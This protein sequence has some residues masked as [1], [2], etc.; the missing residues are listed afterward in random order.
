[1]LTENQFKNIKLQG[2]LVFGL[3]FVL[4][5]LSYFTGDNYDECVKNAKITTGKLTRYQNFRGKHYYLYFYKVGNRY[6]KSEGSF[7]ENKFPHLYENEIERLS[8]YVLYR[9]EGNY[10][11]MIIFD[12]LPKQ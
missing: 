4:S 5:L 8:I 3:L 2:F 10:R 1:M 7:Y 9:A 12:S 6:L 11:S